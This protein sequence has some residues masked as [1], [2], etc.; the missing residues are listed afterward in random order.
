MNDTVLTFTPDGFGHGLYSEA[1]DL[2]VLG[3]LQMKRASRI[4]WHERHQC[5]QVRSS[6]GRLIFSS[7]LRERCLEWEREY[8]NGKESA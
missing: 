5:W 4:E 2:S 3:R 8:F 7:P 1:I 6:G